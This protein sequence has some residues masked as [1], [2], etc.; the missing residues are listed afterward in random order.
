MDENTKLGIIVDELVARHNATE[1]ALGYARYEVLRTL[2]PKAFAAL[3]N[4]NLHRGFFD[5]LVDKMIVS[6]NSKFVYLLH[7]EK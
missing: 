2:T 3:C 7:L 6:T 1:L 5:D 4:E